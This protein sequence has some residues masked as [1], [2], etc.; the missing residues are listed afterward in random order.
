LI[1]WLSVCLVG[2]AAAI[3]AVVLSLG[4]STAASRASAVSVKA[5]PNP[6]TSG[7]QVTISGRVR[8]ASRGMPVLLWQR[9]GKSRHYHVVARTRT[10]AA[11]RF[12]IKTRPQTNRHWYVTASGAKSRTIDERVHAAV[13][14]TPAG[15]TADSGTPIGLG[16]TVHPG[17]RGEQ[18]LIEQQN[19][20][21]W[22][23]IARPRLN[24]SSSF[25][26]A[27]TFNQGGP[28]KLRARVSSNRDNV[29]SFSPVVT[30]TVL[31]GIHK[32]QHVVVIMQ[33]NRSF[34]TYFGTYPGVMGAVTGSTCIPNPANPATPLCAFAD[35][36][37]TNYGGPHGQGS[38]TADMDCTDP[39]FHTGCKMDGFAGQAEKGQA[40]GSDPNNPNCSPCTGTGQA[41][42]VDVMGYH[43]GSDIPNYWNYAKDF[44]LQDQM[45]EP[46]ASWSLPQHLY[47]VSEWSA[48]CTDP[49]NPYSCTND[50]Q[51]ANRPGAPLDTTPLYAWTDIT[52]LLHKY[53][54]SWNYYVMN[55]TEPDC[56]IDT[57]MT[58]SPV[59]QNY[60]TPGIWNPLPHFTDVQQDGQL[61]NVQSLTN[62]FT[63]AKAGTLP[64]VSWVDP[65]GKVSEH[66]T[67]LVSAGQTYVTG[68]INAIMQSPDWNST[69]IFLSWDDWGGF[70]DGAVPPALD[71]NGLGLRVPGIVISPFAK[72]GYIDHQLLSHDNYNKFIE[73]DFLSS[74]RLDP[75]TDGRPDPR[76]DVREAN[77]SLGDLTS[78]FNFNQDPRPPVVLPVCPA[79]ALQPTPVC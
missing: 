24:G 39:V 29:K 17:P 54:V 12:T 23:V 78:D 42:C 58:C 31:V 3:A 32:I 20:N 55:G 71:G 2:G 19:G 66:P 34:D 51:N 8:P 72:Q 18:V 60:K 10:V 49:A 26:T 4:S 14:L 65:S 38:A 75:A 50:I 16:G 5:S 33:E 76:P 62:F 46:N 28:V 61:G 44:V 40:C 69:A 73:D 59:P 37:D 43:D 27:V 22:Q 1:R 45:F 11:G 13:T 7:Q 74:Q 79:T 48:F 9:A 6:S 52:W 68:V 47:Q 21:G 41:R 15:V 53:G 30:I 36:A 77:P 67:N 57:Q 35:H 56:E 64:A 63:A 70:Y 25:T